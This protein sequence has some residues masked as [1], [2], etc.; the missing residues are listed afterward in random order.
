MRDAHTST[1]TFIYLY[2]LEAHLKILA[3]NLNQVKIAFNY[4][5]TTSTSHS[6][7]RKFLYNL[8]AKAD[9]NCRDGAFVQVSYGH[10]QTFNPHLVVIG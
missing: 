1:Y 9:P 4:P 10:A 8:V 5:N 6:H 2:I 3:K 7:R